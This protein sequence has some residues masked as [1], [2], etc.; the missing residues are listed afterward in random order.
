ML[1]RRPR[2]VSSDFGEAARRSVSPRRMRPA[3][4]S[5]ALLGSDR[6]I[7]Q[8]SDVLPEP[9]SPTRPKTSPAEI[10]RSMDCSTRWV[11][12]CVT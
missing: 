7:A 1:M 11:P 5:R 2:I 8:A 9:N 3:G 10:A 6:M 4:A 12:P